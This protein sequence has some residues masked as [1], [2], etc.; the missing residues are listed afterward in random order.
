MHTLDA[1]TAV[2]RMLPT[3]HRD[4]SSPPHSA[5]TS[6]CRCAIDSCHVCLFLIGLSLDL[7]SGGGMGPCCLSGDVDVNDKAWR[8]SP[9]G[10]AAYARF[11]R[12][13]TSKKSM[14]T[15]A[16]SRKPCCSTIVPHFAAPPV[17]IH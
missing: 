11:L 12:S 5:P 17:M 10:R 16:F 4:D 8:S 14:P 6:L 15:E 13:Q 9:A 3:V 2:T 1:L 7:L